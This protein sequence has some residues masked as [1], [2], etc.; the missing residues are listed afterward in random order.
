MAYRD[1]GGA[2][3]VLSVI[4]RLGQFSCA[5]IVLEILSRFAYLISIREAHADGRVVYT[6]VV[7][8]ITIPYSIMFCLPFDALFM[9]FPMDFLSWIM[10][11]VAFCLLATKS[12]AGSCS[13]SWYYDYWGY[14]WGR[15]W[16]DGPS[17]DVSHATINRAGCSQWRT[18]LAFTFILSFAYLLSGILGIYVF[19]KYVKVKETA[20]VVRRQA[21]KLSR[22]RIQPDGFDQE[23]GVQP[24]RA[25]ANGA[26]PNPEIQNAGG[27]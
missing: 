2:H 25:A 12:H 9:I 7:A 19:R 17:G 5:V 24:E 3:K 23:R 4:L 1:R 20:Q 16:H 6:M 15:F 13:S 22:R 27:A 10:W 26:E 11:L 8:G 14:Y 21:G 18:V